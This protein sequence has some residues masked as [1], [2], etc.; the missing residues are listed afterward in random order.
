MM[1]YIKRL[2][3]LLTIKSCKQTVQYPLALAPAINDILSTLNVPNNYDLW[4]V[5]QDLPVTIHTKPK[6]TSGAVK[7]ALL[8]F[9]PRDVK[10]ETLS[11]DAAEFKNVILCF[12]SIA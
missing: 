3:T 11:F 9:R 10:E 8:I 2:G 6:F 7:I 12:C 5:I 4:K 1:H